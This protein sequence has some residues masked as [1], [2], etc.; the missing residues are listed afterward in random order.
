MRPV[1]L[2]FRPAVFLCV[3]VS[4]SCSCANKA[5]MIKSMDPVMQDLNLAVNRTT[6]LDMLRDAMPVFLVQMD[7]FITSVPEDPLLLKGA[8]SYYGYTFAF[9]EDTDRQRASM[10]YAKARDY[11]LRT[12]TGYRNF[13][14]KLNGPP[15]E[16]RDMLYG[17]GEGNIGHL[18]WT[19]SCWLA[20][21]SVN[22]DD[23][24]ALMDLPKAQALLERVVQ[25]DETYYHGSALILL[26]SLYASRPKMAGG[27]PEKAKDYFDRAFDI[28][29]GRNLIAHLMYARYYSYQIQDRDLFVKTLQHVLATPATIDPDMAFI[30]EVARRKAGVLLDH[31]D[32]YF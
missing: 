27:D 13:A 23:P 9:V 14:E 19:G 5:F 1:V 17:F 26:G 4:L 32:E 8:E 15:G 2:W 29:G 28:T 25:I 3:L 30:N 31:V 12:M 16:F 22:T 11:A 20:W 24:Q 10:L 18:F 6:D 21:I 7:G